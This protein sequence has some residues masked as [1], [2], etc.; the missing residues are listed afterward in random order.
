MQRDAPFPIRSNKKLTVSF[1]GKTYEAFP[2]ANHPAKNSDDKWLITL[3]PA[4]EGGPFE[5]EITSDEGAE[6]IRDIYLGDVWLCSGQSNMEMPMQRLRD[7]YG[8]EWEDLKHKEQFLTPDSRLPI[9]RQFKAAHEFDFKAPREELTSGNWVSVS[10]ETLDEFSATAWF[11]AKELYKKYDIPIGLVNTAWGGTPVES[12]MSE[13]ALADFPK[14]IAQ[15]KQ[16]ADDVLCGE[17]TTNTGD[18]IAEWEKNLTCN[19]E[20]I[21]NNWHNE[22]TDISNWQE[23]TLPRDFC[24]AGLSK[25]CGVIWLAMEFDVKPDFA[26]SYAKVLLGTIVDSDSVFIN[27]IKIGS[28]DYRYPPRV[29][30]CDN[31]IKKGKNRIVIRV[32]CFNGEGGITKDKPFRIAARETSPKAK[33]EPIELTGVWK[34]KIGAV[35]PMRPLEF[36]FQRQPVGNYNAMIA[37]L[38]KFPMKGVIWYQGESNEANPYEYAKLFMSMILDWRKTYNKEQLKVNNEKSA[39]NLM[40]LPFLFVQLPIFRFM[41]DNSEDSR[42][43]VLR[44][45]Q[46]S[47]LSLPVTGMAAA[48]EFGEWNDLHP[49]DKK[50]VGCRLFLAAEKILFGADNTSPGPVVREQR[51]EDNRQKVF[52]YFDNCGSGLVIKDL[53]TNS[54]GIS[55]K[56]GENCA[57]VTV[58]GSNGQN[59]LPVKI[60]GTDSVSIDASSVPNPK[61]ILYAWADNPRDRQ[62]FNT[63]GLPMLPFRIEIK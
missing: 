13:E 7:L 29:Y 28:T 10:S 25:F 39:V 61:K 35:A 44:E 12:W 22:Q 2:A 63:E 34:Y 27:G 55:R 53:N 9:I 26:S 31:L 3:D 42:W 47:A 52:I 20:G 30:P 6:L 17:I 51:T 43:A 40:C 41:T 4:P 56:D 33:K 38:L 5:M 36:F 32:T 24:E 1:M 58:I 8:G 49:L 57:F 54:F 18:A 14:K 60:E 37:P 59:R 48:L 16:Y 50:N 46:A 21:K 62:L 23:I 11:F 45:A 19:D 15:G